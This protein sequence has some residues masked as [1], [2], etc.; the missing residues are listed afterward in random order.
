MTGGGALSVKDGLLALL[1][2]GPKHG[3][4]LKTEFE[5][6]IGD[7]WSLNI[8]QVYT[9]L[10]RLERDGLVELH[11][12]DGERK[13]YRLTLAG[14]DHLDHWLVDPVGRGTDTRDEVAMKVLLAVRCGRGDPLD[15]VRAQRS[16]TVQA[17]QRTTRQRIEHDGDLAMQIHLDRLA[18][19][20]RAELD[21][22]DLVEERLARAGNGH[23]NADATREVGNDDKA[24]I[25]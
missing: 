18:L 21:W 9:S 8:G 14:R 22:L 19:R 20:W 3:Y 16:A 24:G 6:A 12:D 10:Q 13:S 5:E 25:T 1:A 4:Q 7:A 11:E 17:L 23:S 2:D 15:V